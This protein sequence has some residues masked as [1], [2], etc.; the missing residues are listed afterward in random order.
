MK[1][2]IQYTFS[3]VDA[4]PQ[5][6]LHFNL[7]SN[8]TVRSISLLLLL[9]FYQHLASRLAHFAITYSELVL[10]YVLNTAI[11]VSIKICTQ[12][13]KESSVMRYN[14]HRCIL[15]IKI[16]FK[17]SMVLREW[18]IAWPLICKTNQISRNLTIS[19]TTVN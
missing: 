6:L 3:A 7:F 9:P 8:L 12:L 11:T 15:L 10:S 5:L 17:H 18:F 4:W 16:T 14:N 13:V 1:Q 2:L 19:R